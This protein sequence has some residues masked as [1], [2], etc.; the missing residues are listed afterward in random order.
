[1]LEKKCHSDYIAH[2]KKIT[3]WLAKRLK[4]EEAKMIEGKFM[5]F[6]DLCEGGHVDTLKDIPDGCFAMNKIAGAYRQ[7]KEGNPMMTRIY[8]WAFDTKDNLKAHLT[9]LEEAKK[10]DHRII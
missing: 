9:M 7:G 5:T 1:M 2:Y 6:L 8:G 10:R 4:G 3:E